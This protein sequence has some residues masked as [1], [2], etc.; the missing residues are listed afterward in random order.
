MNRFCFFMYNATGELEC[1]RYRTIVFGYTSSPFCLQYILKFHASLYHRDSISD[2]LTNN[3]YVDNFLVTADSPEFL[4]EVYTESRRR[5]SEGGF[6]LR[7]WNT[8]EPKLAEKLI[9]DDTMVNHGRPTEKVLGYDYYPSEDM[10]TLSQVEPDNQAN[11]KR[12]ILSETSKVFDPVGIY[13]PVTVKG[14]ILIKKLWTDKLDWDVP[15]PSNYSDEWKDTSADLSK[16]HTLKF[17]RNAVSGDLNSMAIFC[18]ASREAYGFAAY[19][20]CNNQS[21]F[22]FS[23]GKVSPIKKRSLPTLEL[24]SVYLA[25]KCLD[26]ILSSFKSESFSN[27][28]I[29]V[30]AQIVLSWLLSGNVKTK[31]I[32]TRNRVKDVIEMVGRIEDLYNIDVNFKYVHTEENV[33]DF[34]TRGMSFKSFEKNFDKWL[35]GPEW[36]SVTPLIWP[37]GNLGCLSAESQNIM[38]DSSQTNYSDCTVL[39]SQTEA[40]KSLIEYERFSSWNKLMSVIKILFTFIMLSGKNISNRFENFDPARRASEFVIKYIQYEHFRNEI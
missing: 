23:K 33:A 29:A 15:I 31:N 20:I 36:L 34:I 25:M 18:D 8:N 14:R 19:S 40:R 38:F 17:Q 13:T 10:I 12:S 30:D 4:Q 7:S 26:S 2:L 21:N 27:I 16:L 28:T 35:H 9:A 6:D 3:L 24:L 1:Y 32:F 5:L 39:H 11:T 37:D 22:I